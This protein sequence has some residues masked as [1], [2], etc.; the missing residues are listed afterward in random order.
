MT[1]GEMVKKYQGNI[2]D[3]VQELEQRLY[4]EATEASTTPAG[5]VRYLKKLKS[6]LPDMFS[7][8]TEEVVR[9]ALSSKV[10]DDVI[11]AVYKAA[12]EQEWKVE[13]ND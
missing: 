12:M 10:I 5:T 8:T 6:E 13:K 9:Y 3:Q 7:G 4:V 2:L 1:M 11:S